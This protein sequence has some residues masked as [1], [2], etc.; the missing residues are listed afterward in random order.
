MCGET[1]VHHCGFV[2]FAH[3]HL[4]LEMFEGKGFSKNFE[5]MSIKNFC[6]RMFIK[7]LKEHI[8]KTF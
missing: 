2:F 7:H 4:C 3:H 1:N 5:N 8:S 6:D